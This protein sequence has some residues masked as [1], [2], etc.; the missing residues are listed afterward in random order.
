LAADGSV[1]LFKYSKTTS[2]RAV[3]LAYENNKELDFY[4]NL[5]KNLSIETKK[6]KNQRRIIITHWKN[7]RKLASFDVF[8]LHSMKNKKVRFAH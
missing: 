6:H 8:K 3:E 5:F 2:L 7:F 4:V 1:D